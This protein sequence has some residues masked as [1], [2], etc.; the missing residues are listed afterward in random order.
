MNEDGHHEF[1]FLNMLS[2]I[3]NIV[4]DLREH[5]SE[6]KICAMMRMGERVDVSQLLLLSS[7]EW[8]KVCC[9]KLLCSSL[10]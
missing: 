4:Y 2:A 8:R 7:E 3:R 5:G 1:Y 10:C 6:V 9:T